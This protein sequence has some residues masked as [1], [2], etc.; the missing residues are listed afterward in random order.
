MKM[1]YPE[2]CEALG[3]PCLGS[4]DETHLG[5]PT[6]DAFMFFMFLQLFEKDDPAGPFLAAC[7]AHSW[8][9]QNFVRSTNLSNRACYLRYSNRPP[10]RASS[11]PRM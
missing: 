6:L 1:T 9:K 7:A 4:I 8:A 10:L 11:R 2:F 5:A 3:E